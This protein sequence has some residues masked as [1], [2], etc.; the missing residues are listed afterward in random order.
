MWGTFDKS[1]AI[2]EVVCWIS[3]ESVEESR[4]ITSC[5]FDKGEI[6]ILY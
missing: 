6:L 5:T 3:L 4:S 1:D 2:E